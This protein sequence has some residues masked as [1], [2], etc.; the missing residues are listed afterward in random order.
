[1]N[2]LPQGRPWELPFIIKQL[3]HINIHEIL[4]IWHRIVINIHFGTFSNGILCLNIPSPSLLEPFSLDYSQYE[5]QEIF[6]NST[7]TEGTSSGGGDDSEKDLTC[8]QCGQHLLL[9]LES[10]FRTSGVW[11][12]RGGGRMSRQ[13]S[14]HLMSL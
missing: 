5:E 9:C 12:T 10:R 8:D 4:C 6:V 1:M 2:K 7:S 14:L 11:R 3:T 13:H